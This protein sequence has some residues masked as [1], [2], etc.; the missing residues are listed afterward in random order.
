M[1]NYSKRIIYLSEAQKTELFTN[2]TVTVN[3]TTVT[4]NEN[5]IYV[6]PQEAVLPATLKG[7]AGGL[8]ELDANGK[9]PAMQLDLSNYIR[10]ND[11]AIPLVNTVSGTTP[12]ISGQPNN[13]YVC[14][15]VSTITISPPNGG[16][17]DVIFTSGSTPTTLTVPDVV[18]WPVWFDKTALQSETIYEILI[19][20]R[21]YGSVMTWAL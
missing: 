6:T 9:V 21:K 7:V 2:H 19:T 18:K 13:R 8:A 10:K 5:D 4:Y 20:D 15:E 12:T 1:P 17:I 3:G 16:S 11:Y 14:G